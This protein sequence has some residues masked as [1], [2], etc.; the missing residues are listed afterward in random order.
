MGRGGGGG[1]NSHFCKLFRDVQAHAVGM[2][3]EQFS[4]KLEACSGERSSE[5]GPVERENAIVF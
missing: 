1:G 2:V 5:L 3:F 4:L